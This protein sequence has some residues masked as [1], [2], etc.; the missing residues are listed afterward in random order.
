MHDQESPENLPDE[1]AATSA[2]E[3]AYAV[4]KNADY[5]RYLF[6]RFIA[7]LGQQMLVVAIDWELYKRTHSALALAFVGLS[8]MIP[9]ILCTIPA[10]HV[11]DVFNRKKIVLVT[12][13]LLVV[14]SLALT[15]LSYFAA[16]VFWI[17]ICLFVLGAARTFLWPASAAFVT[18]LVPRNQFARAVTFNSGAFQLSCVLGPVAFG[19]VIAMTPHA[20]EHATAWTVYAL[21]VLASIICFALVAPIKHVHKAK[22]AEPVSAKS[23]VEGFRFVYQNKVILGVITLDMFAVFLGGAVTILPMF[24]EN[25]YHVSAS[26]FGWLRNAMPMGAVICMFIIA[27]RPPLQKAGKAMLW[28]VAIFGIATIFFGVANKNC[29]DS[30]LPLSN[31]FWFWFAFGMLALAGFVDNISVVV[32]QT[33]VQILTPDEKRG[34]VSA[35]NALFIGTSNELGGFRSGIVAWLFTTP[36]FLGGKEATGAIVST[37]TGGIGTILVVLAVAWIWPEIRKYGK[38]A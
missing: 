25:I 1:P 30:L 7:S 29:F 38:L 12:T 21:N 2:E 5:A 14:V 6:G 31:A 11:A 26:G 13:L 20:E 3:G 37:V 15:L 27:H 33:L 23:L 8:L 36:T 22:P 10:G 9:M 24:A 19:A 18:S 34:R 4:L 28:S 32:R 16:K 35:V 17:Y